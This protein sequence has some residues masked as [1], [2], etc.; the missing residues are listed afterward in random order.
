M[1]P[2]PDDDGNHRTLENVVLLGIFLVL[3]A[4]GVWLM[5]TMADTRKSL[6][7]AAQGRRNCGTI[8]IPDRSR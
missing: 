3:V 7:C 1:K 6:D 8:E 4:A 5:M 2:P